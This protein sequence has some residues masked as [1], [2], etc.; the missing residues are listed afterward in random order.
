M[1]TTRIKPYVDNF[2]ERLF[3]ELI[4]EQTMQQNSEHDNAGFIAVVVSKYRNGEGFYYTRCSEAFLAGNFVI[5]AGH[6][7]EENRGNDK[8]E[9]VYVT[10]LPHL[11]FPREE[12]K[13]SKVY[14]KRTVA[15]VY[16]RVE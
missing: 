12:K 10:S 5:V 9:S 14:R 3:K 15:L 16:F 2:V 1:T 13:A 6:C 8:I 7:V 4:P 11:D